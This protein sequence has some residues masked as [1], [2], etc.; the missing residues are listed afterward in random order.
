MGFDQFDGFPGGLFRIWSWGCNPWTDK[1]SRNRPG[2]GDG[3][4]FTLAILAGGVHVH[5]AR[6]LQIECRKPGEIRVQIIDM[7]SGG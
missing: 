3:V 5:L 2:C 1:V 4:S 7:T 6:F